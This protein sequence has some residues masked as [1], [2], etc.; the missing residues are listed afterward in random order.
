MAPGVQLIRQRTRTECG[1]AALGMMLGRWQPDSRHDDVRRELGPAAPDGIPAG[2]LRSVAQARGLQAFLI[3]GTIDDLATELALGHP[4]LVGLQMRQSKAIIQHY[5]VV[6]GL[7][8]A[9]G[10]VLLADPDRGWRDITLA[11]FESEWRP[12]SHLT[13]VV[14]PPPRSG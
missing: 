2:R 12:A 10:R 8:R 13:L 14:F 11:E 1:A 9:R 4:V 7:H 5:A 6:V 3:E